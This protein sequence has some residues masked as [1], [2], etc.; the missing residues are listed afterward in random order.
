[1]YAL[2]YAL[3]AIKPLTCPPDTLS[4]VR[5]PAEHGFVPSAKQVPNHLPLGT[6]HIS[7]HYVLLGTPVAGLVEGGREGG[8][9]GGREGGG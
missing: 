2:Q 1:M 9:G 5:L 4:T 6:V 3:K 7:V 8:G